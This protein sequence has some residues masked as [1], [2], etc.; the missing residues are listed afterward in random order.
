MPKYEYACKSCGEHIEVVQSF[1]DAPLTECPSC[2]G[3]LR[4]V[5][6]APGISFKGSGFYRTDNRKRR[7]EPKEAKS[8][9]STGS[10]A[11]SGSSSSSSSEAG[12]G[13]SSGSSDGKSGDSK[14]GSGKKEPAPAAEA[15]PKATE[16]KT[17]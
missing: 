9:S 5:F 3:P 12:S 15:K 6:G 1:S 17:A 13:G 16:A 2:G 10:K 8:D 7:S 14:D 11:E 4:K